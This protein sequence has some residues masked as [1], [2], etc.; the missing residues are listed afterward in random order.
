MDLY[1][2]IRKR[3]IKFDKAYIL[4]CI[5]MS[6]MAL[7]LAMFCLIY[8][9]YLSAIVSILSTYYCIQ[10]FTISYYDIDVY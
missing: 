10:M 9:K 8:G 7:T 6:M 5:I 1:R 4:V 3:E 2:E